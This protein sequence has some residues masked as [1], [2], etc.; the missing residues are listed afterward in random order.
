MKLGRD[1]ERLLFEHLPLVQYTARQIYYHLP[2]HVIFDDIVQAGMLGLLDACIKYDCNRHVQFGIYA[3]TRIRGAILD[4]LRELDSAPRSLRRFARQAE[5]ARVVL[6]GT[7]ARE[8]VEAEVA[9]QLKM[10]LRKFQSYR[11]E[12]DCLATIS[13]PS[14]SD[15]EDSRG[16]PLDRAASPQEQS[17]DRI[18]LHTE[19]TERLRTLIAQLPSRQR[20]VLSL[21]Y[22]K[23]MTMKEVGAALGI[24]ES[25]VSQLHSVAISGLREQLQDLG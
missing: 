8:P 2:K 21:Y 20:D 24:G 1:R 16:D 5:Q 4:S 6:R 12:L 17:P 14:D 23:D 15:W 3:K 18:R 25:R 19:L 9:A 7:L 13:L 22:E 11:R 10:P